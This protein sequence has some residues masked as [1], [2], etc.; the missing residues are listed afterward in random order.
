[1]TGDNFALYRL[2]V[3]VHS[4]V[5]NFSCRICSVDKMTLATM[6]TLDRSL[7]QNIE[8]YKRDLELNDTAKTG[9]KAECICLD[10]DGFSHFDNVAVDIL[11]DYL[12]GCCRYV[13]SYVVNYIVNVKKYVS[14]HVLQKTIYYF[15]SISAQILLTNLQIFY[16]TK[17]QPKLN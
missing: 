7:L 5:A 14:L 4:C 1:M 3:Y 11:N 16:L 2:L 10:L 8:S 9:V 17:K 6:T 12:E 13:L 15:S